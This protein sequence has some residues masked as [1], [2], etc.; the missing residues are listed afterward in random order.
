MNKRHVLV[1]LAALSTGL[2]VLMTASFAQQPEGD[3]G[4]KPDTGMMNP[5]MMNPGM[6]NP[7]MMGPGMMGQDMTGPGMMMPG[8]GRGGMM[9]M[10][11]GGCPM[12]GMMMARD[13][14]APSFAEGRIAFIKAE[15]AITDAQSSV[16]EA[17]AAALRKNLDS[18]QS[19]HKAMMGAAQPANP[20]QRLDTH[21]SAMEAR[22]QSLKDVKP[23]LAGLYAALS[24]DQKKKADDVL[25]M[26]C[27][28]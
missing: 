14:A 8:M 13:G 25:G 28:M 16:W 10:M 4:R 6:M 15:L 17:Y 26:G 20:V 27:M 1:R 22:L 23:A 18:M 24:E 3:E 2:L 12:M 9:G 7:G 11:G 21:I 5:G 19:M